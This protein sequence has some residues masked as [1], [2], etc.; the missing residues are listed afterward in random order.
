MKSL[1]IGIQSFEEI[2]KGNYIYVDKT[3]YLHQMISNGKYYFLSRPRRFGKSLTVD[4]IKCLFEGKRELFEGLYIYDKWDWTKTY[5]VIH[6]SF[7]SYKKTDNYPLEQFIIARLNE[8][9]QRYSVQLKENIYYETFREL[10]VKLSEKQ[11]VV[12]L[13]DEYDKPIL[14]NIEDPETAK[15]QREVLKGLYQLLKDLDEKI[16]FV[17]LT[18]VSK[19]SKVSIFSGLNNLYDITISSRYGA[20]CGYT[21]ND[22][23]V[24]FSDYLVNVDRAKMKHWYNGYNWGTDCVYN[25]FD[26]LWFLS[27]QRYQSYWFQTGTPSFLIKL[28]MERHFYIPNLEHIVA[29]EAIL[30]SFDIENIHPVTLL[31]QTGYLTI[32]SSLQKGE[33]TEYILNYPNLEVK[34]AFN[35]V[36]LK[37][38]T[39]KHNETEIY[40]NKLYDLLYD[41]KIENI[42]QLFHS[43]F[44]GIPYQWYINN[45]L[46]EYEGFFASIFYSVFQSLGITVIPEDT[47]NKGRIDIT[48]IINNNIFIFEFKTSDESNNNINPLQQI[49]NKKYHEKYLHQNK[50]IYLIGIEFSKKDRNIAKYEYEKIN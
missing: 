13:I 7:G 49:K 30:S 3:P 41:A 37:Y 32:K 43:L 2:R 38:Y 15:E 8:I 1:P 14:D 11:K 20:I 5:P 39:N 6:L 47:T 34:M 36:L 4:T 22:M 26:I 19:F 16:K 45:H 21:E 25:P 12:I 46:N 48:V 40:L 23:D 27:E 10:I 9:A 18:G 17:F 42:I 44:A 29:G 28:M 31:F 50:N 35:D 33:R 24:Y